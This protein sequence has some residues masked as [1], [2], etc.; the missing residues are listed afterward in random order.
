MNVRWIGISP[1]LIKNCT[2]HSHDEWEIVLNL[3]GFGKSIISDKEYCFYPGTI[4]C[5]PP[6]TPHA[7]FSDDY[8]K[9]IFLHVDNFSLPNENE[10]FIFDDDEEKSIETLLLMALRIFHKK[11]TGYISIVNSLNSS[12][13]QLL[14]SWCGNKEKNESVELLKNELIKNFT[15]PEFRISDATKTMPYSIDHLRRC[16]KEDTGMSPMTY[17][18][19]LRI[20]YA[21]K[22][23]R[24]KDIMGLNISEIS[25]FSGFYDPHYFSRLFKKIVGK[26]P[27]NYAIDHEVYKQMNAQSL[28]NLRL[29]DLHL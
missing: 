14:L 6:Y 29:P 22:L 25:C 7:K 28:L 17:L 8:F 12:I 4:M 16:F 24:Q 2:Y 21:R 26:T 11:E 1:G 5:L 10:I 15:N 27:Q 20:E 23:L 19:N 9:D 13:H 3:E 18:I